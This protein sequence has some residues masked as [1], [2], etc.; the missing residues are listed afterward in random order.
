[1]ILESAVTAAAEENKE[2]EV[3]EEEWGCCWS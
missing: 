3:K 2:A 1:M